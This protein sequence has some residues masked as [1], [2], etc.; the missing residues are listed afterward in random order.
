MLINELVDSETELLDTVISIL[1]RAKAE[2]AKTVNMQQ[3]I[4][5]LDDDNITP[6]LMVDILNRHT[7]KLKNIIA[8]STVDAIDLDIVGNK[9]QM[10]TG[11]EKDT[12]RFKKTATQQALDNLKGSLK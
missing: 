10:T 2:G 6:E 5:D 1:L 4:N 7:G 9:K 8:G 11:A 12:A 3:L